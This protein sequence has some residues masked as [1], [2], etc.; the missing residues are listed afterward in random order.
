MDTCIL[1]YLDVSQ[2]YLTCSVTFQE[3]TIGIE[4]TYLDILHVFYT[5]D[6]SHNLI[7]V[8]YTLHILQECNLYKNAVVARTV[9]VCR[10]A[11]PPGRRG[12]A[13]KRNGKSSP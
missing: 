12:R 3:N 10:D 9:P 8:V 2:T 5:Y 6:V 13:V 11:P 1:M 7:R 4:Y